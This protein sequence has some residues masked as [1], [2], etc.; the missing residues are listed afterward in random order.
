L[1]KR[2]VEDAESAIEAARELRKTRLSSIVVTLGKG[3]AV[4]VDSSGA[5]QSCAPEVE[6]VNAVGSGDAFLGGLLV[7]LSRDLPPR[8]ALSW[9]IAGGAANAMSSGGAHFTFEQFQKFKSSAI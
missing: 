8:E 5:I 2:P 9:G 1:L 7:A 6:T 3:G 4:L